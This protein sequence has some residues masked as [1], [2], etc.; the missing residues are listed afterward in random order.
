MTTLLTKYQ[1]AVNA[2]RL[3]D[4]PVQRQCLS[5]L[6]DLKTVL[7]QPKKKWFLSKKPHI[8]GLYSYGSVGVGKTFLMNLFYQEVAIPEKKRFHFHQFMQTIDSRLRQL[9]GQKNPLKIIIKELASSARLLCIDEFMV[10][11]TAHAMIL[12]ELMQGLFDQGVVL[13]ATSNCAPDDLYASGPQRARFLPAIAALKTHCQVMAF[14][15]RQ[16]YRISK[17]NLLTHYLT[18]L[19]KQSELALA[20]QFE[21]LAEPGPRA[22]LLS[23]Q[24]RDVACV[25]QVGRLVWF[26]FKVL[27]HFPR[28]QLDYLE[29]SQR[30]DTVIVSNIP[31]LRDNQT[32][33]AI[34]LIN[35]VDVMYDKGI[36]LIVS[37]DVAIDEI[38]TEGEVSREFRRTASRLHEMQSA[39]YLLRHIHSLD[40]Y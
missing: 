6:D 19:G 14:G 37:A 22:T 2:H 34:L 30:F 13:L 38:Y 4:D 33:F 35:F 21:A 10:N 18:P 36:Q 8:L 31:A 17:G 28:S 11:D 32:G 5:V 27:C 23:I 12:A 16:D 3:I 9:Q 25:Q 40:L 7:E 26:D 39:E 20:Q 1:A 29:I 15:K 24:N